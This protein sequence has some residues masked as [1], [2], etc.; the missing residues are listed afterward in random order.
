ME[1][2][3]VLGAISTRGD[4]EFMTSSNPGANRRIRCTRHALPRLPQPQ[5]LLMLSLYS[6]APSRLPLTLWVLTRPCQDKDHA[7]RIW[8]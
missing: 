7:L 5:L 4:N 1:G 2:D 3:E 6:I 8:G